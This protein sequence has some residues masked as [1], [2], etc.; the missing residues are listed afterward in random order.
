MAPH[1]DDDLSI[2][3]DCRLFRRITPY[4][5][6]EEGD[7]VRITSAALEVSSDGSGTS[8]HLEDTMQDEGVTPAELVA[9]HEKTWL[10]WLLAQAAR[11]EDLWI[12]RSPEPEDPT[13][14][15]IVGPR[16]PGKRKRLLRQMEWEVQPPNAIR[17]A[18]W[19]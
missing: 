18:D 16:G 5:M 10:A 15:E 3:G 19:H 2:A 17:P 1:S 13:H 7:R 4:H 14:G 6:R 12:I 9:G 8:V 11:D